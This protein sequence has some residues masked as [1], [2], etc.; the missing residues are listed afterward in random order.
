MK[1]FITLGPGL[2]HT[3]AWLPGARVFLHFS[4]RKHAL[5]QSLPKEVFLSAV[6]FRYK[7]CIARE[8]I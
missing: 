7:L 2:N 1:S 3:S 4:H 5:C 6:K 8:N